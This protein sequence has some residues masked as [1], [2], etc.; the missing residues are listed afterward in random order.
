MPVR[1]IPIDVYLRRF[2]LIPVRNP[3]VP[4]E[5]DNPVLPT[6]TRSGPKVIV[7]RNIQPTS[8]VP[9]KT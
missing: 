2:E 7:F 6:V 9:L 3:I 5:N 1:G 4:T 8:G